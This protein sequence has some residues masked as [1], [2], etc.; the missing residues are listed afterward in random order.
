MSDP[1][2]QMAR[3]A[4]L[5]KLLF[6]SRYQS[7]YAVLDGA[8]VPG[9]VKRLAKA[10]EDHM[11]L[12][13]GKL[14]PE[15]RAAAPHLVKLREDSKLTDWILE[16]GWGNHWG[17][18]VISETGLEAMGRHLRGFLRVRGPENEILYFRYYDPR[19]LPVFLPTCYKQELE[20]IFGPISRFIAENKDGSQ[21]I[22]IDNNSRKLELVPVDLDGNSAV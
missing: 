1:E 18:F 16:E 19:V 17:I 3:A 12:Y 10:K 8:S 9:L 5:K 15:L 20:K 22:R 2:L 13:R 21:A 14:E 4:A 7:A 11:C 6:K